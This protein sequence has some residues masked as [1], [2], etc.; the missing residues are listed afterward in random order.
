MSTTVFEHEKGQPLEP[1][2][3]DGMAEWLAEA[4]ANGWEGEHVFDAD[5]EDPPHPFWDAKTATVKP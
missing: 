1:N 5:V 4:E 3:V 2:A